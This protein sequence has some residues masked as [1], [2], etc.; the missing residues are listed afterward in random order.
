MGRKRQK[1]FKRENDQ[2]P[3]REELIARRVAETLAN[4]SD[5]QPL[6]DPSTRESDGDTEVDSVETGGEELADVDADAWD[7]IPGVPATDTDGSVE[8]ASPQ[9]APTAGEQ[10]FAATNTREAAIQRKE[11]EFADTTAEANSESS[12][13]AGETET[14]EVVRSVLSSPGQSLEKSV[15]S[16][17]EAQLGEQFSNVQIHTGPKA[18]QACEEID[19][20]AFTVGNHVVFNRGEY[21]PDSKDGRFLIA[22]ELTHV[23]QQSSGSVSMLPS[24]D[25]ELA[26]DP[27][28]GLEQEAD[29][30]AREALAG[31]RSPK[32]G[33][34]GTAVTIQ[35]HPNR[36][37]RLSE[38]HDGETDDVGSERERPPRSL[39]AATLVALE[40]QLDDAE[41]EALLESHLEDKA[42]TEL[43]KNSDQILSV[44][45][46]SDGTVAVEVEADFSNDS[47]VR[48]T[49]LYPK[50]TPAVFQAAE[51]EA[52]C[53][54][55][56]EAILDPND[57]AGSWEQ[58]SDQGKRADFAEQK[59]TPHV[60]EEYLGV[61]MLGVDT[62]CGAG[63]NGIDGIA[64]DPDEETLHI[65]EAKWDSN[66]KSA[67]L[68]KLGD[69]VEG[70]AQEDIQ[71][72]SEWIE[73][74][75]ERGIEQSNI[76]LTSKHE[77]RIKEI[78]NGDSLEEAISILIRNDLYEAVYMWASN[79]TSGKPISKQPLT[80]FDSNKYVG[81]L[82][83]AVIN[84]KAGGIKK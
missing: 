33:Y 49:I 58:L 15:R 57:P 81:D 70:T 55:A 43:V 34:A 35:R 26:I 63:K 28:E 78:T 74:V 8:A 47:S 29:R 84:F 37:G 22:H 19:A 80:K 32:V 79:D 39:G 60:I 48:G 77:D 41:L 38:F 18:A 59:L 6:R 69:S 17:M 13:L 9:F 40:Q 52:D 12:A 44:T 4:T 72:T 46:Q 20:R 83:D 10:A 54:G 14:P 68:G 5:R 67:S 61:E 23:A 82:F 51:N 11:Q 50:N 75:W 62:A 25:A 21:S 45:T 56:G 30:A 36:Q 65:V 24:E 27:D 76:N 66:G 2:K 42:I 53:P 64:W 31:D 71:M 7:E 1:T 73:E 16:E 3:S